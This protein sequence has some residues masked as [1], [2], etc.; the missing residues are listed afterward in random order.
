MRI[1]ADFSIRAVE[2]GA[3]MSW[4]ASPMAGVERKMLDRIGDEIAR[5]T[6]IVRY[7]P[8]SAFSPHT[9][10]GG[11]EFIV[12]EGVFSDEHG[13][14]PAG[15]YVRNPPNSRHTP[16]SDEGCTIFVKLRQFA[17]DD[18]VQMS[19]DTH[20]VEPVPVRDCAG[21]ERAPLLARDNEDVRIEYWAPG[22]AISYLPEGGIEL[23]CLDG[24][25]IET[26]VEFIAHSWLRLP[27]GQALDAQAGPDGARLWV[28]ERHL[29]EMI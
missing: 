5:A 9:H 20:T 25:F 27:P 8:N 26:G 7:A 29:A 14:Y 4:V 19:C 3:R 12:L 21:V 28:K 2:H 11:E 23:L 1:N 17:P 15:T 16:R 22:A 6:S 24:S 13:D 10:G 18:T